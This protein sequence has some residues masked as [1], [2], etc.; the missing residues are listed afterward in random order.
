ML[1]KRWS[2]FSW[3][4]LVGFPL[5]DLLCSDSSIVNLRNSISNS[6]LSLALSVFLSLSLNVFLY[7]LTSLFFLSPST[8]EVTY[9]RPLRPTDI[10]VQWK[11]EEGNCCSLFHYRRTA[12][13]SRRTILRIYLLTFSLLLTESA[14]QSKSADSQNSDF[15]FHWW[16]RCLQTSEIFASRSK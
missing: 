5:E 2:L 14:D 1:W 4:R 6:S 15:H 11:N 7:L 13:L 3:S 8:V 10:S 12:P 9:A 16:Q